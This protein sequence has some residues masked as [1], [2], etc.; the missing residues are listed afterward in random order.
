MAKLID[1][2]TPITSD[3][4][5]FKEIQE[6]QKRRERDLATAVALQKQVKDSEILI[7]AA[8]EKRLRHAEKLNRGKLE[9]AL[10]TQFILGG[11]EGKASPFAIEILPG[12][13]PRTALKVSGYLLALRVEEN[14]A[15]PLFLIATEGNLA[16]EDI[17]FNKR[18]EGHLKR[19]V[20]PY[21][22]VQKNFIENYVQW[23]RTK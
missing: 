16:N 17:E 20:K 4:D 13:F 10:C 5:F 23:R 3:E 9:D 12:L 14:P 2:T 11:V 6:L 21:M 18:L 22:W 15:L 19:L 1:N 8:A 7:K